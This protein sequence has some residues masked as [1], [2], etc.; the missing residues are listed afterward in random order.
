MAPTRQGWGRGVS[1]P[2]LA[3]FSGGTRAPG[4]KSGGMTNEEM[5]EGIAALAEGRPGAA[6]GSVVDAVIEALDRGT[7]RVPSRTATGG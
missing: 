5:H 3:T 7:L 1:P 2:R 6:D 4:G